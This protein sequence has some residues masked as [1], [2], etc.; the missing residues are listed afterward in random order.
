MQSPGTHLFV[1]LRCM[2]IMLLTL[3]SGTSKE[4]ICLVSHEAML[5]PENPSSLH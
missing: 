3:Q 4:F 5:H 2:P 1:A